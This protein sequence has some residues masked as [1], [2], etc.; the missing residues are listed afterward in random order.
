MLAAAAATVG[1]AGALAFCFFYVT[2]LRRLQKAG[3]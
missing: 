3:G 2:L 1:A